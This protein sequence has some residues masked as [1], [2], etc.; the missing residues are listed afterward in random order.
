VRF[1]S[2]LLGP[3]PTRSSRGE[4]G[5]HD[6]ALC[7]PCSPTLPVDRNLGSKAA[8]AKKLLPAPNQTGGIRPAVGCRFSL[9]GTRIF[10]AQLASHAD[11][12]PGKEATG[13]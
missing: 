6:A 2:P 9:D 3:L 10:Q 13:Q 1:H 7:P 12:V 4:D 5:E 8:N 11:M